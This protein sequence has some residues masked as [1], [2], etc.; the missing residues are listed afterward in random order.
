MHENRDQVAA[1][2]DGVRFVGLFFRMIPD[3]QMPDG[4]RC[5]FLQG[6]PST[7]FGCR[8]HGTRAQPSQCAVAPSQSEV[9]VTSATGDADD[10]TAAAAEEEADV[11][12]AVNP[13]RT[14][15]F[16]VLL[17]RPNSLWCISKNTLCLI[18]S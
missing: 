8:W 6:D 15:S 18:C 11:A 17:P 16:P 3:G 4:D 13:V 14:A 1:H 2:D 5:V 7:G 10:A 12:A 9:V